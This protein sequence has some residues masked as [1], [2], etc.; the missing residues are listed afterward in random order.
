MNQH[1]TKRSSFS[2]KIG[3]VLSA[4]GASV[5]L[6]NIWRFPYLA[7]KYGGGIFLVIYIILALTFGY[8]M[9]IAETSL[10]RMTQKSPVGAYASFGKSK[11]ILAGGWI[12][13]IIPILI[14]PYYSVIGGWVVKYLVEYVLGETQAVAED[15]YFSSFI[16]DGLSTEI[17]FVIFALIVLV[18]I[19]AGVRNGIERVSK[20]MMPVLVVLSLVIT[21]YSVTRP[22]ALAGVKYFLVPNINNFSWMTVVTAMGQ[23]FYS[24]SIAM[25]ILI[26]FGSYMKKETSIEGSTKQVEVF[27]T[28]IAMLAGLMIIPAVYVFMGRDGMSAGPG[29]MFISLPKVFN[30]MGIAGDIVGLIFF[31][32]V[33]F[34]AVTSSVSIMEAIVSSLI[35]RFHWSR[36]KSAILVTVYALIAEIIVCLGYN[37]LYMEVKLPNGTVGQILDIMD[38]VSNNVLMPIVALAT[39]ILVGWIVSPKVI[40]DEVTRGGSKFT[41]KGLYIIMVKFIAPAFLLILL[42]QALGIV[43]F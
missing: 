42:L 39:C 36:R 20:F 13:A 3:F 30:E 24:L 8:T 28:A 38:Y 21:V 23:M 27:D 31:M 25:G 11:W 35:D 26:T 2:G 29:L 6:G 41:R 40:I 37:K 9:I 17:Y 33:A 34:A 5:G 22:G 19:Y 7:A 1:E 14:V 32:I 12:N 16:S 10:G 4:A 43:T 15:G 18:I